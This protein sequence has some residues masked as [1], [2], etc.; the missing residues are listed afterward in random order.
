MVKAVP[1]I[2]E[3]TQRI[4][5]YIAEVIPKTGDFVIEQAPDVLQQIVRLDLYRAVMNS[6]VFAALDVALVILV[7][8]GLRTL[9]R[10]L[11]KS[12]EV[13]DA[14]KFLGGMAAG[15]AVFML[16]IL[17]PLTAGGVRSTLGPLFAPKA[18]LLERIGVL[19]P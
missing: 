6:A 1:T 17:L 11:G 7:V 16:V 2:E 8:L 15:V 19:K 18:H 5:A 4:A 9:R 13:A 3:S 12:G 10:N 14:G